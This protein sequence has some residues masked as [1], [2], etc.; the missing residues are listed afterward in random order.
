MTMVVF[1]FPSIVI[2]IHRSVPSLNMKVDLK[3]GL[4]TRTLD[5][6]IA[7]VSGAGITSLRLFNND[8]GY[9]VSVIRNMGIEMMPRPVIMG[10]HF[11]PVILA[12][13]GETR[14]PLAIDRAPLRI[15]GFRI[16]PLK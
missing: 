12:V 1:S 15:S 11:P 16:I 9:I 14:A 8:L 4:S 2:D 3:K 6:C 13:I 5:S 10:N 7:I